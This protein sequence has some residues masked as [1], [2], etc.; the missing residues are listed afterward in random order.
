[1]SD[2]MVTQ[3]RAQHPYCQVFLFLHNYIDSCLFRAHITEQLYPLLFG[4]RTLWIEALSGLTEQIANGKL[5]MKNS[6]SSNL[7]GE[8]MIITRVSALVLK[9][10]DVT[11]VCDGT[12]DT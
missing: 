9:L 1:M 11:D 8:T 6:P 10:P 2:D 7:S 12:Q 4:V 3:C 5:K